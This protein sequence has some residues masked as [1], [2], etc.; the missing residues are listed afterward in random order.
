MKKSIFSILLIGFAL[1]GYTQNAPA[2]Q[3]STKT[4]TPEQ[5]AEHLTNWM[6]K[7]LTLTAEQRPKI[8]NVNLKYASLNQEART[9]DADDRK[10]MH[11][12]LK[13]NETEREAEF[14]T[15]LTPE[16]FQSFQTAKQELRAK[17]IE[18][19]RRQ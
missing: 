17:R 7:K 4:R 16:Q 12:E 1:V 15:I 14:K 10:A 2:T 5:R 3:T 13:A 6:S 11:Q 18:R 8:Y 9:N 19:R